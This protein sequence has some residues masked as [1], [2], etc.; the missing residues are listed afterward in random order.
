MVPKKLSSNGI[1]FTC[2]TNNEAM[3]KDDLIG[4][5]GKQDDGDK[6]KKRK[7]AS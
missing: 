3:K 4:L 7:A 6:G 2:F 5:A 1:E